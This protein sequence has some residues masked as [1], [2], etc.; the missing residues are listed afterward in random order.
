MGLFGDERFLNQREKDLAKTVFKNS[1]SFDNVLLGNRTSPVGAP[2]T[3]YK[4]IDE[5][6]GDYFIMHMGLAAFS[7]ATSTGYISSGYKA[8]IRSTFIHELTHVWQGQHSWMPGAYQLKSLWS[9]GCALVT[10]GDRGGAYRYKSGEAWEA[11][12]VEQQ[13]A[14][15]EDWF[16]AGLSESDER[17]KYIKDNIRK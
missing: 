10:T 4:Y 9:Q 14:I 2:C 15:V 3:T 6:V 5:I 7:D 13:A 12:N 11:Y 17:F 8:E 1:I 16:K